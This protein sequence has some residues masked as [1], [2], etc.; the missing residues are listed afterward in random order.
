MAFPTCVN[1]EVSDAVDSQ[2]T[3]DGT[4]PRTIDEDVDT[5]VIEDAVNDQITD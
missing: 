3:D 5:Q 1:A 2:I 4:K